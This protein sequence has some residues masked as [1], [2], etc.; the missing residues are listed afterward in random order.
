MTSE[1]DNNRPGDLAPAAQAVLDTMRALYSNPFTSVPAGE[2]DFAHL[3][4]PAYATARADF[5]ARGFRFLGDLEILEVSN[6]PGSIHARTM[7]RSLVSPDGGTL[8]T[9]F[10]TRP[11]LSRVLWR[12]LIGL[13]N[14]RWIDSPRW[15]VDALTAREYI[16]LESELSDGRFVVTT[17]AASAGQM[18]VPPTIDSVFLPVGTAADVLL[19]EHERRLRVRLEQG[20]APSVIA[21][22]TLED[23]KQMQLRLQA[24]KNAYRA[25]V[26]W[27]SRAELRAMSSS[28]DLADE[29][30]A[31]VQKLLRKRD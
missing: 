30:F 10:Q 4:L 3:N 9:Y 23:V 14:F 19:R 21:L 17:N 26:Q 28:A 1:V 11:R 13:L 25:S 29:V 24:Q 7:L 15:A 20:S 18:G 16:D 31:E 6:A 8:A 5:E 22:S 2:A 27:V 12:L